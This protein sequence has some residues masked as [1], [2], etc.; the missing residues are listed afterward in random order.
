LRKAMTSAQGASGCRSF[1]S[2]GK[3]AAAS[4]MTVSF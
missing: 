3:R 4:P 2:A 1:N